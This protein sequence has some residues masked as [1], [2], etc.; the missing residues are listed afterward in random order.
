[1]AKWTLPQK[2]RHYVY[3]DGNKIQLSGYTSADVLAAFE[4]GRSEALEEAAKLCDALERDFKK[5]KEELDDLDNSFFWG[6]S[7]GAFESAAEIRRHLDRIAVD[8]R[9]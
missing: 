9:I 2:S 6:M 5:K 8:I 1:M 7:C 4:A 3:V